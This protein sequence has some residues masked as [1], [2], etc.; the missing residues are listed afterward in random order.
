MTDLLRKTLREK[1]EEQP[2]GWVDLAAVVTAGERRIRRTRAFTAG[3]VAIAA[4]VVAVLAFPALGLVRGARPPEVSTRPVP[5]P[6]RALGHDPAYLVAEPGGAVLHDGRTRVRTP[7]EHPVTWARAG[8]AF[9]VFDAS[10]GVWRVDPGGAERVARTSVSAGVRPMADLQATTVSWTRS[11]G[12]STILEGYDAAAGSSLRPR[13]LG[14]HAELVAV[15]RGVAY[16]TESRG[17]LS[18]PVQGGAPRTVLP[19]SP[20]H[21]PQVRDVAGGRLLLEDGSGLVTAPVAEPYRR[22][23]AGRGG[24]LSPDGRLI[25]STGNWFSVLS[26][27]TGQ[28]VTPEVTGS[29]GVFQEWLGDHRLDL[30]VPGNDG[31]QEIEVCTVPSGRCR[32]WGELP[33]TAVPQGA[34]E[35]AP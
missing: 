8:A 20:G 2:L 31:S 6:V 11:V 9:V 27:T 24:E 33:A 15:D 7:I 25:A 5:G 34:Y 18:A 32:V 30:V 3:A 29:G 13:D 19:S 17:L 26:A 10:G 22:A 1:A 16:W 14:P 12:G 23:P 35:P 28:D 21:R 4:A